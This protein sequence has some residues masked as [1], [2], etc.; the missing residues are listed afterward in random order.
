MCFLDLQSTVLTPLILQL[1][2]LQS[3]FPLHLGLVHY[4]LD[5]WLRF[6]STHRFHSVLG[7]ACRDEEAALQSPAA[8]QQTVCV[9]N[10]KF[11]FIYIFTWTV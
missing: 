3:S 11:T 6:H 2:R 7:S 5:D 1:C 9:I 4:G 10:S 8:E